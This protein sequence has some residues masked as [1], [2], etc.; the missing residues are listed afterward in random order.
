[1]K[2]V[3]RAAVEAGIPGAQVEAEVEGNRALITVVSDVFADMSRVRK[4]QAVYACI[5]H[6]I[7][8]GTLHAVTIRALTPD[9]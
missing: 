5:Q 8:D 1:M 2:D 6:L 7:A 3:I 4:Q 9:R